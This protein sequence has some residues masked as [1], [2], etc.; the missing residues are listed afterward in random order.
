M[1]GGLLNGRYELWE[2]L[3]AGGMATVWRG[4]DRVLERPV[5]VKVLNEGLAEDSRFAE[6]FAREARHSA[7]LAHPAIVT[8]FDSGVDESGTPYLV[9]ELVDGRTLAELLELTP[10]LPV[11]RAVAIASAVCD[12]LQVAHAA[13][14]VHRD[15]KPGNIMVADGGQVKVVDFG[16]AKA[17]NDEAQLTGTGSVLGTAAYLA[18]EQATASDVDGRADLYALGCVLV[19]M[20]TGRP[21]FDGATPVDVAWKHVSERPAP[22]SSLRPDIPPALDAAVLGLLEKEPGRRPADAAAA[23]AELQAAVTG[24]GAATTWMPPVPGS[25]PLNRTMAM[26]SL[27]PASG[28]APTAEGD[29]PPAPRPR[30]RRGM[31]IAAVAVTV[32]AC[33]GAAVAAQSSGSGTPTSGAASGAPVSAPPPSA[34]HTSTTPSPRATDPASMIATLR[35]AVAAANLTEAQRHPLLGALD[36]ASQDL[37][38]QRPGDAGQAIRDAQRD[39]RKLAKEHAVDKATGHTWSVRLGAISTALRRLASADSQD[40]GGHG[41]G[42][43]GGSGNGGD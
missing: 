25:T 1:Q 34:A 22:P 17:G 24:M 31:L 38:D 37:T 14:L 19:E 12:A 9:M 2:T 33:V 5:A 35:D 6:R 8:V 40:V 26:P 3:G 32:L 21:P 18:P 27:D 16:I 41:S 39:L 13:G 20:L 10:R 42:G 7:S 30:R 23:R 15:I 4:V 43:N 29:L 28:P 11:E 36:K